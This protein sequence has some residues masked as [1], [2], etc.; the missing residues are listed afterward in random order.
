MLEFVELVVLLF[1]RLVLIKAESSITLKL[2]FTRRNFSCGAEFLLFNDQSAKS[3]RQKT[4]ETIVPRGKSRQVENGLYK[5]DFYPENKSFH[6]ISMS[7]QPFK[8]FSTDERSIR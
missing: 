8:G 7:R 1:G 4:K 5:M 6:L 3:E 2:L